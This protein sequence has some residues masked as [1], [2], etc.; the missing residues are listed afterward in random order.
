MINYD[1]NFV[2]YIGTVFKEFLSFITNLMIFPSGVVIFK[3]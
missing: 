3:I 2:V 1:K